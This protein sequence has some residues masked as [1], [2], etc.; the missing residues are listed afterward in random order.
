[1]LW[2]YLHLPAFS[3]APWTDDLEQLATGLYQQV[4]P[5]ALWPPDGLLI[6]VDRLRHLYSQPEELASVLTQHLSQ[7]G[8]TGRMATGTSPRMARLLARHGAPVCT[9]DPEIMHHALRQ[10]P[11]TA[12]DWPENVQKRLT[13]M[14]LHRL[15]DLLECHPSELT[16]RL[17][18]QWYEDL[19]KVLGR[20]GDP[21]QEFQPQAAFRQSLTLNQETRDSNH[22]QGPL[23]HLLEALEDFLKQRQRHCD[24]LYL[25]LHHPGHAPTTLVLETSHSESRASVFLELACLR[26]ASITLSDDVHALSV[27]TARLVVPETTESHDLF[28]RTGNRE[29]ERQV[30]LQRLRAR[31]GR[32]SLQCPDRRPDPRPEQC[33]Y[34]HPDRKP[35]PRTSL[36]SAPVRPF[37]LQQP[38]KPLQH[39]PARWLNGPE[40]LQGGWW[41]GDA[42]RRD[43]YIALMSNGQRAWLFRNRRNQWF[44]HGWF[45]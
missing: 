33:G 34:W 9:D 37:W 28:D 31:L 35:G 10:L 7:K 5:P 14:G 17:G 15:T 22:L 43:Y 29:Q 20:S 11:V 8:V 32:N 36:R 13:R 42:I 27:A 21:V 16:P 23:A 38:P 2:L 19:Q 44:I 30:L 39:T 6:R 1:M 3:D 26:L 24:R 41:N 18:R 40:R 12:T 25:S 45:G 4:A